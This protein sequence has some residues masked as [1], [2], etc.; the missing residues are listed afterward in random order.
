MQNNRSIFGPL[1]LIA[2]GVVWLLV[3]SG[4][5]PSENLWAL[6]HI[7]PY[8]LIVAGAGLILRSYWQYA[9][10]VIDVL[11]IG[12]ILLAI[13]FAPAMG[14]ANPSLIGTFRSNGFYIGPGESGSGN[15]VEETRDVKSFDSIRI[16]FPAE[17]SI[18]QGDHESLTIEAEDNFLPGLKTEVRGGTLDIYYD[19]DTEKHVNPTE[20]VK[21]EIV[22]TGLKQVD[23]ESAGRLTLTGIESNSLDVSV[24]GAGELKIVDLAA[25]DLS[26]NMSGAGSMSATGSADNLDLSISGFGS[27]NGEDLHSQNANVTLSGAGSA[28][29]WVDKLLDA[30]IS[31]AGSIDYYG[32]ANVTRQISGLGSV[33][34]KGDK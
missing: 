31:G 9:S 6:T 34:H 22:V 4:Y 29:V 17:V 26:V 5:I 13:V 8:L 11:I 1:L 20:T 18:S 10:I 3:K 16:E 2:A 30:E 14:W 23:F 24:S 27:F 33:T 7:W 28:T 19:S 21:I 15:V 32:S 12:G 25:D